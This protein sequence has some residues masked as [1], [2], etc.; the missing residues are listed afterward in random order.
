M[1]ILSIISCILAIGWMDGVNKLWLNTAPI[2]WDLN[3]IN[4]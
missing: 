1:R 2:D 4:W 3:M